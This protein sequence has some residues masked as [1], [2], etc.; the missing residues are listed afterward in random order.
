MDSLATTSHVVNI[1]NI[2][3]LPAFLIGLGL[4]PDSMIILAGLMV[5][6][7]ILSVIRTMIIHGGNSFRSRILA[8]GVTSKLLV[9]F[10]P[11]IIVYTGKG[12]GLNFLPIAMGTISILVLAES[13]SVL[14]H[15][16]SI[17][18]KKDVKEFDAVSLVL[19]NIREILEK[20]L[21]QSTKP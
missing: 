21:A 20:L 1:K 19:K 5:T 9:L 3:Y 16:Q 17:R 12:A 2:G 4:P 10:I 8:H 7:T 6:D 11:I 13:Y 18:T 14:G 15:I